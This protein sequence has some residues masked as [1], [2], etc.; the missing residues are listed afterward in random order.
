VSDNEINGDIKMEHIDMSPEQA[1]TLLRETAQLKRT[2]KQLSKNQ[3]IVLLLQQ[4]NF[5][6][7]QQ[8][9]N[10]VLLAEL[11]SKETVSE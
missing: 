4:V 10:K 7:E 8:N 2:L 9:I 5:A 11:K 1:Q 3:L 6:V